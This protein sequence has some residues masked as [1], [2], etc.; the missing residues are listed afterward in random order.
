MIWYPTLFYTQRYTILGQPFFAFRTIGTDCCGCGPTLSDAKWNPQQSTVIWHVVFLSELFI[1]ICLNILNKYFFSS[2]RS[3]LYLHLMAYTGLSLGHAMYRRPKIW[4]RLMLSFFICYSLTFLIHF[5][6]H[7]SDSKHAI[8]VICAGIIY[9][10][11]F[12]EQILF[13]VTSTSLR[14]HHWLTIGT[15][16]HRICKWP[17]MVVQ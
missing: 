13:S 10:M 14:P 2:K 5:H 17:L 16:L 3:M 11:T 15:A 12:L 6:S 9:D 8:Y 1:Y 4:N 7:I